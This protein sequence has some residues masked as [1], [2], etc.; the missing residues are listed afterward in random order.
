[1]E[2]PDGLA[3]L[4]MEAADRITRPNLEAADGMTRLNMEAA[5]GMTRLKGV[6]NPAQGNALGIAVRH[7]QALKGRYRTL[8]AFLNDLHRTSAL[9]L[10][11]GHDFAP[12]GLKMIAPRYSQGVALGCITSALQAA[13]TPTSGHWLLSRMDVPD[14]S[15]RP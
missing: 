14:R 10:G 1:M 13:E 6:D 2:A 4:Q 9:R 8:Q 5:D 3:R 11:R 7:D 12:S 15:T